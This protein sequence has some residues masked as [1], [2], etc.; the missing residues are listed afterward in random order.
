MGCASD[1]YGRLGILPSKVPASIRVNFG[2]ALQAAPSLCRMAGR[3]KLVRAMSVSH[4][5][6]KK[7]TGARDNQLHR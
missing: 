4:V 7:S 5:G 2:Y 1:F 6:A 3:V